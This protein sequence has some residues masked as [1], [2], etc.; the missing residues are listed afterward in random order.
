MSRRTC[1]LLFVVV[2]LSLA[3]ASPRPADPPQPGRLPLF[4][5]DMAWMSGRWAGEKDGA[6]VEEIWT[7]PQAGNMMGMSRIVQKGQV[8][9]F[10]MGT[11]DQGPNGPVLRLVHYDPG[12][13]AWEDKG[14]PM[15]WEVVSWDKQEVV[16]KR[17]DGTKQETLTYKRDQPETLLVVL[18][19]KADGKTVREPFL[20]R[21]ES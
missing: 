8:V 11:I 1:R 4:V 19:R 12:L 7:E 21:R 13:K 9:F 6:W 10:E 15:T 2:A 5:A 16:F 18:E 20:Y 17:T 3:A 14:S